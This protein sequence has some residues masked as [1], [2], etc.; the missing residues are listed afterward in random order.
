MAL[1]L[2]V[3]LLASGLGGWRYLQLTVGDPPRRSATTPRE[4]IVRPTGP[5]PTHAAEVTPELSRGVVMITG[6]SGTGLSHGTGI[7]LTSTGLILTNYHVVSDTRALQVVIADTKATYPATLLGR[8]VWADVAVLQL[9]GASGLTTALLDDDGVKVGDA[10]VAV[11]NANG[12]GFLVATGGG[13]QNVDASVRLPSAFGGYGTDQMTQMIQSSAG[14][15]PGYSGGPTFDDDHE[16]VGVTSAGR[17]QVSEFMTSYSIPIEIATRIADDII[18]GRESAQ[19]RVG[20]GPWMGITLGA[21]DITLVTSVSA[22]G[23]AALAGLTTG[24]TIT[25]FNAQP[26]ETASALLQAL[27]S[28]DPDERIAMTWV[29]EFGAERSGEIVLGTSPTN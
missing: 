14:A 18:A 1:L 21:E 23:P 28:T 13:V 24:S 9:E 11:G 7:V 16:V 2:I 27:E 19:T 5:I 25:S 8:N 29:D 6:E 17:E 15:V 4:P 10:V 20:P 12:Q 3:A 22:G 26:T